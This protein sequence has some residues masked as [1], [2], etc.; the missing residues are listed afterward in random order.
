M[1]LS[2]LARDLYEEIAACPVIDA[3]EHLSP[4]ADYLA[5][6]YSGLNMFAGG[7]LWHDLES[8]GMSS[9]FKDTMRDTGDRPYTEWWPQIKP[10]W[11]RVRYTSYARALRIT[12][13]DLYGIDDLNDRTIADF[14]AA[15]QTDNTPGL[16][17]RIFHDRCGIQY[18]I[19]YIDHVNFPHDPY[20]RGIILLNRPITDSVSIADVAQQSGREVTRLE[21]LTIAAQTILRNAIAAGAVG[22][23][24][25]V[26]A[27]GLPDEQ[28]AK[29]EFSRAM[30]NDGAPED[31]PALNRYLL[32]R[33]LDV[34]AETGVPVAVH[35]GYWYDFRKMD[36]KLLLD[37]AMLRPD[38]RFDLFHLGMPMVRD[39]ALIGKTMPNVTLN[40]CWCPI[41]SQTMTKR[42]LDE[43]ID[44]V[45]LN[46]VI[47][48]GGDYRVAVQKVYGHLVMA[49]EVVAAA[50][51]DRIAAGDWDREE[52]LRIAKMW[53]Y[54]N[55]K[56]IYRIT[57]DR[58]FMERE[59]PSPLN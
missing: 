59:R 49:R 20:F 22:F 17:R 50:L 1:Y 27:F 29:E 24:T 14:A 43:I 11:E 32:N 44:L 46:K 6:G 38:V 55:P 33:C 34:A 21:E 48:F 9:A 16:F 25:T 47:A 53:L 57:G 35:T 37:Y 58:L 30:G 23:K 51:A 2:P 36:P 7:Y 13:R 39:A 31:Y 45:P 41:I 10:Y 18:V 42:M 12:M 5:A 40:L 4:E 26:T 56:E 3:H 8:A 28:A 54:D 19:T 52:A 15:V